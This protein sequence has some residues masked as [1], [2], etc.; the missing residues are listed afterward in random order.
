LEYDDATG[1]WTIGTLAPKSQDRLEIVVTVTA[2]GT[3]TNSAEVS[4]MDQQDIDSIPGNGIATED[5]QDAA[6][7]NVSKPQKKLE[8]RVGN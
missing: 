4:N 5:D 1:T 2:P 7:I 8:I 6:T 3:I